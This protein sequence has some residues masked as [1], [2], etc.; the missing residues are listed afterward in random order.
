M[1]RKFIIKL[2]SLLVNPGKDLKL[3]L[4]KSGVFT[5]A[6]YLEIQIILIYLGELMML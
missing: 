2:S 1:V 5:N 3:T 6:Q 4:D